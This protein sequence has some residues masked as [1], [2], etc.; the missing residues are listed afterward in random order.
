MTDVYSEDA[1][2]R[3]TVSDSN[4]GM[5]LLS[6]QV[7]FELYYYLS[8]VLAPFQLPPTTHTKKVE[9]SKVECFSSSSWRVYSLLD[10]AVSPTATISCSSAPFRPHT[11]GYRAFVAPPA[12]GTYRADGENAAKSAVCLAFGE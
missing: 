8:L 7:V 9:K 4:V 11:T 6:Y 10:A 1:S 12:A 3:G 2:W 5:R